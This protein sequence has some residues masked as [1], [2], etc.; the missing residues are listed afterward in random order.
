MTSRPLARRHL[1]A[2]SAPSVAVATT[3][4]APPT[5]DAWV[6]RGRPL[7]AGA[8]PRT[9]VPLGAAQESPTWDSIRGRQ[10]E[11]IFFRLAQLRRHLQSKDLYEAPVHTL[12]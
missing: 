2:V 7:G 11:R 6:A 5:I 3:A 12:L 1:V 8:G 4:V 10:R 9:P